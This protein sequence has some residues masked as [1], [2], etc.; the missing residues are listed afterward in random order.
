MHVFFKMRSIDLKQ[1][2]SPE[3]KLILS[4]GCMAETR[5]KKTLEEIRN[6]AIANLST[7]IMTF[8]ARHPRKSEK[9][10]ERAPT[11]TKTRY[12][13]KAQSVNNGDKAG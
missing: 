12:W 13:I 4:R 11:T 3:K 8:A 7:V 6:E 2:S 10:L 1:S 5:R 9:C